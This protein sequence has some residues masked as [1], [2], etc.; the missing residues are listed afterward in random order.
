MATVST[1]WSLNLGGNIRDAIKK[2]TSTITDSIEAV[3]DVGTNWELTEK[4]TKKALKEEEISLKSTQ[5]EL[6][7][8]EKTLKDLEKAWKK[9]TPGRQWGKAKKAV[10]DQRKEVDKLRERLLTAGENVRT[11]KEDLESFSRIKTDWGNVA[12]QANQFVELAQKITSSFDFAVDI[13]NLRNE[14]ERLT[15]LTGKDLDRFL[16]KSREIAD[17]YKE[18]AKSVGEAA[19][20]LT[21]QMGGSYESNLAIIEEGLKRGANLNGDYLSIL[22][23]YAPTLQEMGV[24]ATEATALIANAAKQGVEPGNFIES[25][26]KSG[27]EIRKMSTKTEEALADIGVKRADLEGKSA[28]EAVQHITKAMDGM[29]EQ[30]KQMTI[31]RIFKMQG[32]RSGIEFIMG[33]NQGIPPLDE[34]PAVEETASGFKKLFSNIKTWAGDAFGTAAEYSQAFAPAI[35]LIAGAIPIM[36]ALKNVTW[37]NTVATG[38]WTVATKI[39]GKTILGIPVIGWILAIIT[40]IIAVVKYTEGWGKAWD[41]TFKGMKLLVGGFV[42]AVKANFISMVNGI[43]IAIDKIKLGWYKFKQAVGLGDSDEN[44][45][46]IDQINADVEKRKDTIVEAQKAAAEKIAEATAHFVAA[47]KSIK[48]KK[49][50]KEEDT[51]FNLNKSLTD[52][53]GLT[54]DD[55]DGKT[56][57]GKKDKD[58]LNVGSGAGGVKN[59]A[60]TLNVTNNF[61]VSKD[62]NVRDIADKIVG[63]VNDRL[64]DSLVTV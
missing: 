43:M 47:G 41:L 29:T 18:D 25:I 10:E 48:I 58:G 53:N 33:L 37:L 60:M 1:E 54:F 7:E 11:L 16:S 8:K 55:P 20:A 26:Q 14:F 21:K 39:L 24:S 6:S 38:A 4:K 32:E 51:A 63:M 45:A 50:K 19:N 31:S 30:A 27:V 59:I 15:D 46:M 62:A 49:D 5:K 23:R 9:A 17:V 36:T 64:R 2:V 57:K 12:F 56:G 44:Q 52:P 28:I 3:K 35:Q 34:I 42:E 22:K 61:S 13:K 40:A